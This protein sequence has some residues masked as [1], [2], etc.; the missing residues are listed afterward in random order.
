MAVWSRFLKKRKTCY[1]KVQKRYRTPGEEKL[2]DDFMHCLSPFFKCWNDIWLFPFGRKL[3]RTSEILKNYFKWFSYGNAAKFYHA[4]ADHVVTM[5]FVKVK[6][7]DY[8]IHIFFWK[9]NCILNVISMFTT[10]TRQNTDI[11]Q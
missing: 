10:E 6:I 2:K 4:N 8:L 7:F 9:N 5:S 1:Y 3:A 11:F